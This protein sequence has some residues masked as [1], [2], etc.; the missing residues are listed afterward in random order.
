MYVCDC[1]RER[2]CAENMDDLVVPVTP[3]TEKSVFDRM[4]IREYVISVSVCG[5]HDWNAFVTRLMNYVN[6]SLLID[7]IAAAAVVVVVVV[8]H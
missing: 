2:V 1:K 6:V 4:A 5:P 3:H 7:A 8:C